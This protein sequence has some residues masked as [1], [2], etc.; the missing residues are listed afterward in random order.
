MNH[1]TFSG[2]FTEK[3]FL[4]LVRIALGFFFFVLAITA[5]YFL[6]I[7]EPEIKSLEPDTALMTSF[8]ML[9]LITLFALSYGF[10]A[11][12]QWVVTLYGTCCGF[13]VIICL[14]GSF[15]S[16][17]FFTHL[18]DPQWVLEASMILLGPVLLGLFL[19]R[20]RDQFTLGFLPLSWRR[21][22]ARPVTNPG[23]RE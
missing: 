12:K 13:W 18:K 3:Y 9:L 21:R 11:K 19:W 22:T 10:I 7:A 16:S 15:C 5:C 14:V 17:G 1:K 8:E 20:H 4:T 23:D 2:L 6:F